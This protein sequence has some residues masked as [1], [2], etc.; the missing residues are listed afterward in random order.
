MPKCTD[1]SSIL[2]IGAAI[3]LSGCSTSSQSSDMDLKSRLERIESECNLT[4]G[5]LVALDDGGIELKLGETES[6]ASFECG[7]QKIKAQIPDAKMGFVGNEQLE[8]DN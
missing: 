1:I 6:F 5:T 2:V 7:M 3:L 4:R 8:P